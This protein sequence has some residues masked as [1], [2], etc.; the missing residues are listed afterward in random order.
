MEQAPQRRLPMKDA[1]FARR[2]ERLTLANRT[3]LPVAMW[4][5][6]GRVRWSGPL[7]LGILAFVLHGAQCNAQTEPQVLAKSL[8]SYHFHTAPL[9]PIYLSEYDIT[10]EPSRLVR[11][12]YRFGPGSPAAGTTHT[13]QLNHQQYRQLID[14]LAAEGVLGGDW[15]P[16]ATLIGASQE[17]VDIRESSGKAITISSALEPEAKRRFLTVVDAMRATVPKAAWVAK[18]RDQK[19]YQDSA[20]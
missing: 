12:W 5:R 16:S 6:R 15:T 14:T 3:D 18:D 4:A 2:A 13:F 8:L 10:V 20:R 11:L 17:T 7:W 9:A 1:W 19:T